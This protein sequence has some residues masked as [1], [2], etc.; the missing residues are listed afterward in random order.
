MPRE[1][2]ITQPIALTTADG[3]LNPDAIGWTRRPLHDTTSLTRP[4]WRQHPRAVL[5]HL[6]PRWGR[7]KRWEYWAITTDTHVVALTIS[8]IDYAGVNAL[9]VLDRRT[10]E[11]I[12]AEAITPFGRGVTLPTGSSGGHARFTGRNLSLEATDSLEGTRL[13]AQSPRVRLDAEVPLPP[14]HERLGVVVPWSPT[15]FQYTIKDVARPAT[16]TLWVDGTQYP[17]REG[18]TWATLDHGRGRWPYRIAWNWGAGSGRIDGQVIGLQIGGRWTDGTGSTE[19][20]LVIDGSLTK[21]SDDVRWTYDL[22]NWQEPWRVEGGDVDLT[23]RPEHLREASTQ[24]GVL[25]SRTSQCFGTWSGRVGD[26]RIDDLYGWA[27]DVAQR[28]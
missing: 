18:R 24:L 19:N 10:G 21:I 9:F 7:T 4:G 16:G 14:G 2:E 12:S 25:A 26:Q 28:W 13:R 22:G 27:E 15:R 1:R 17:L 8:D 20:A 11:Q 5:E 23:F 6:P 3:R